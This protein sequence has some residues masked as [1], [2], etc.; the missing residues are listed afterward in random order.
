MV[1]LV[2]RFQ[3]V[4]V[5]GFGAKVSQHTDGGDVLLLRTLMGYPVLWV[6]SVE[7]QFLLLSASAEQILVETFFLE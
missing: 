6:Q 3:F 5:R 1:F 4:G 2:Q 7:G